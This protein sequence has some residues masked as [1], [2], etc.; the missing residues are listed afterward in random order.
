[1]PLTKRL[2]RIGASKGVILS[3]EM[4]AQLGLS[5]SEEIQLQLVG[6]TLLLRRADAPA[7][8]PAEIA[9]AL[10]MPLGEVLARF[11]PP[12]EAADEAERTAQ[13]RTDAWLAA[14]GLD[15]RE[16]PWDDNL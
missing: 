16:S 6:D 3:K 15:R 8:P 13:V 5:E 4:L 10:G 2:A 7:L 14:G 12:G 11:A 1:M 9:F